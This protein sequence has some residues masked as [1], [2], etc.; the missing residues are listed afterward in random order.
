[1]GEYRLQHPEKHFSSSWEFTIQY[2]IISLY[3]YSIYIYTSISIYIYVP[4]RKVGLYTNLPEWSSIQFQRDL[5]NH[6]KVSL[7]DPLWNGWMDDHK[8]YTMF[9]PLTHG[10]F[11]RGDDQVARREK[12]TTYWQH[13]RTLAQAKERCVQ[14]PSVRR[15]NEH[16]DLKQD[17]VGF[18][19]GTGTW[20]SKIRLKLGTQPS[21]RWFVPEY[22]GF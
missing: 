10:G 7:C 4:R 13:L 3:I 17:N 11:F 15:S 19:Q 2:Y 6:C 1:M 22:L 16:G 8:P 20:P 12:Q 21:N 9:G 5:H 18:S 14:C